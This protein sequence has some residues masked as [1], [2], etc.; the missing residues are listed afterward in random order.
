M[1]TDGAWVDAGENDNAIVQTLE[2]T[3]NAVGVFGYSF[4]ERTRTR[5]R[6]PAS[7]A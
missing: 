7:T 3:P 4:L 2:K 1:R 5:S 6:P